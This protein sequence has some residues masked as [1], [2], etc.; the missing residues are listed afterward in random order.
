MGVDVTVARGPLVTVTGRAVRRWVMAGVV[1]PKPTVVPVNVVPPGE[2]ELIVRR[3][4]PYDPSHRA[5]GAPTIEVHWTRMNL[6]NNKTGLG[7]T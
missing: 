3:T 1:R 4:E 6:K 2:M 7:M 5:E